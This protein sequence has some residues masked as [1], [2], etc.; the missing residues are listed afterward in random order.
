MI[1]CI[2]FDF[3]GTLAESNAIKRDAYFEAS[4]PL[5][6]VEAQVRAALAEEPGNR[7]RVCAA[8]VRKVREAGLLPATRTP[9]AWT[10]HLVEAYTAICEARIASCPEVPGTGSALE[11]LSAMGIALY[12]NSA[13]PAEPLRRI[14]GL[15]G[16][17]GFFR[18]VL[19]SPAGKVENLRRVLADAQ[20]S[21]AE[22]V[23]VGDNEVDRAAADE[24]GCA[25]IGLENGFSGYTAR[26]ETLVR[27]M[28]GLVP[29]LAPLLD[30]RGR[31]G[32]EAV[33]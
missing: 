23:F 10:G 18:D 9:E 14:L 28:A 31:H 1:R 7:E 24:V 12:V 20:A 26:P 16:M 15:R 5:G 2:A 4:L 27:D 21:P 19:G 33:K 3:D 25:F 32:A 30:G 8:I 22:T 11:A 17:S 29:A 13:T 6:R